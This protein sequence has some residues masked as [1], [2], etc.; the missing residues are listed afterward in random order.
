MNNFN[1]IDNFMFGGG[2]RF[3]FFLIFFIIIAVSLVGLIKGISQWNKNNHSPR[4]AVWSKIVSKRQNV[5][6]HHR[7]GEHTHSSTRTTYY[8]TFEFESKD[9]IELQVASQEY[10]Y[11]VEGDEGTLTFQGT[12][13][14]SFERQ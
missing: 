1:S 7:H 3:I 9:R 10:G 6:R 2:F 11:L 4:L 12:R 13:Y 8:V 14:V 5:D